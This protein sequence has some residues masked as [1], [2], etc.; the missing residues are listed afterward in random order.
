V[1][2]IVLALALAAC[3]AETKPQRE[4]LGLAMGGF[5]DGYTKTAAANAAMGPRMTT[6]TPGYGG[7]VTCYGW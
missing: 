6:C 1:R 4:T 7:S 2:L 3:S 5:L